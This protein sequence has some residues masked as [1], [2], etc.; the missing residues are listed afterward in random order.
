MGLLTTNYQ[1]ITVKKYYFLIIRQ[2]KKVV[3]RIEKV[4]YSN[5]VKGRKG[6][7]KG[8]F[9]T[10]FNVKMFPQTIRD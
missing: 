9:A 5:M 3:Y 8:F 1:K 7:Q 4:V 2:I 10:F 6:A